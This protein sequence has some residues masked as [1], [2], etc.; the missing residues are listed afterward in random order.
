M[1]S[2]LTSLART[3]KEVLKLIDELD[4]VSDAL[5]QS[6][7]QV[8][9]DVL[10]KKI[11]TS[12][13][14]A[15]KEAFAK[16]VNKYEYLEGAKEALK[17]LRVISITIAFD[18]S[19]ETLIKLSSWLKKNLGEGAVLDINKDEGIVGGAIIVSQGNWRDFSL[20]AKVKEFVNSRKSLL[21]EYFSP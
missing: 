4:A 13:S 2:D 15:L 7:P 16:G 18:A 17:K 9:E 21:A 12:C 8:L 6:S 11:S 1:Y 10:A 14:E 19:E 20:R 3:K 5:Y